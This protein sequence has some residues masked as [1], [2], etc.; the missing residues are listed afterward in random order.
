MNVSEIA[1]RI[2]WSMHFGFRLS[3]ER[4]SGEQKAKSRTLHWLRPAVHCRDHP[5][6]TPRLV[7]VTIVLFF[8]DVFFAQAAAQGPENPANHTQVVVLGT[9]NP[10]ADPDRSGPAVAVVVNGTPYLVDCG[11]G[12]VRRAAAAENAGVKALAVKNLRTVFITHLHSDH[13]LGYPDLIFSPWVLNRGDP[14][15]AYGPRGLRSMTHHI[16]KA[17]EKDVRVRTRGLE[18]ANRTGYKVQVHEI[19]PGIVYRDRNMTVTAFAVKHGSWDQAFGYRFDTPDRRIVISGDTAPTDAIVKACDGCD[20][21]LHEIYNTK[22]KEM[23]EAHW[24]EYFQTFHTSPTEVAEIAKR[25]RP[26][27]LVLYHQVL[28][29]L[30]ESDLVEQFRQH[31]SGKFVFAQDLGVY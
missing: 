4:L 18:E 28:H 7:A 19:S 14:L 9:G 21:L 24:K 25:A 16:L 26:R 29:D 17:W 6:T 27:L 11:P 12:V 1:E 15:V 5:V 2:F 30:P 22:G 23:G 13:T 3:R 10:N 20:L 31:Y 8:A